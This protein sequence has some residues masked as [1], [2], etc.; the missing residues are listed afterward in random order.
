MWEVA[1]WGPRRMFQGH[2]DGVLALHFAADGRLYSGSP[3]T[4][5]LAWDVEALIG[6]LI[7]FHKPPGDLR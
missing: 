4:T 7:G 6:R 2:R 5:V 1:T 3:D